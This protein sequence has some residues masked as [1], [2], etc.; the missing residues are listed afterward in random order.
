VE[1]RGLAGAIRADDGAHLAFPDVERHIAD[2]AHAAERQR[3][4]LN[5]EQDLAR[6]NIAGGGSPHAAFPTARA[7]RTVAT[8]RIVTRAEIV[9]LRPSSNVTSVEMSA[10]AEP[11]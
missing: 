7:T 4:V 3:H 2:G 9:P 8:S 11:S 1:H 6:R 10:S 5:R